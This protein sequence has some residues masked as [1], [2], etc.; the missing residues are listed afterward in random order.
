MPPKK[1]S[2][3]S[4]DKNFCAVCE[5][6]VSEPVS[7][8]GGDEAVKCEGICGAWL[9]RKCAGLTKMAFAEVCKS[10]NPFFCAQCKIGM[11]ERELNSVSSQLASVVSKLSDLS[12]DVARLQSVPA[13]DSAAS[14]PP[15]RPTSQG[16]NS[17]MR[18]RQVIHSEE[19]KFNVVL[20]GVSECQTGS[21][22]TQR[23]SEDLE[24]VASVLSLSEATVSTSSIRDHFRLGKF[25]EHSSKP[26][27]ILVKF[28]R[29]ADASRVLSMSRLL[30][31]PVFV[32][33]DLSPSQRVRDSIL[34]KERWS[35]ITDGMP[36]A[37]IKIR[38][39]K[40]Y[41][42]QALFGS[43]DSHNV[44]HRASPSTTDSVQHSNAVC[45]VLSEP[46][47]D[48][49]S[50]QSTSVAGGQ[51]ASSLLPDDGESQDAS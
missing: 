50:V 41:V 47:M 28:V 43:L 8:R 4:A 14:A 10:D 6:E 21:S 48:S 37:S 25:C 46:V 5:E 3:A 24:K 34:L 16:A 12:G 7:G 31:K 17:S 27:P 36:R 13:I 45:D 42:N 1:K 30:K 19:R 49:D 11:L 9:H 20:F 44:F 38:D 18:E 15:S 39:S 26:R 51:G 40:L 29:A 23:Q 32:K 2:P 33:P 35:L 22:R